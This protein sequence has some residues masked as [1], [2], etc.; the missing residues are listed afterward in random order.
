MTTG[1]HGMFEYCVERVLHHFCDAGAM[2]LPPWV[3]FAVRPR[4][5]IWEY[6]RI[7]TEELTLEE[8]SVSEYLGF[9]EQLANGTEYVSHAFFSVS[10]LDSLH[11]HC[12]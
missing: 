6:L 2:V 8:M 3:G 12:K 1:I 7:N 11:S 9:K 5:G 4:P 10:S